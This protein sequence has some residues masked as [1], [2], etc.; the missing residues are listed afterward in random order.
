M[1]N[2]ECIPFY[3][4]ADRLAVQAAAGQTIVGKRFVS[5]SANRL[6]GP[7]IPATAQIGAS[8]P[9]DGGRIQVAH[10]AAGGFPLGVSSWDAATGEGLDAI[11]VG[12]V[13]VTAAAAIA[14]GAQVEVGANGQV[15]TWGGTIAT[16]PVGVCVDGALSGADAQIALAIG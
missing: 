15:Q 14:A 10:T 3:E 5:P 2:N 4:E 1:P 7:L 13:P 8:D 12:V 16:R 11:R 6:S 9:T